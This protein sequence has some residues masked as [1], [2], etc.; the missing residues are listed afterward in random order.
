MLAWLVA[1]R[2]K[3]GTRSGGLG[4]IFSFGEAWCPF[5]NVISSVCVQTNYTVATQYNQ[6]NFSKLETL[7]FK[8]S[9][10]I[11]L[12]N[13]AH[14]IKFCMDESRNCLDKNTVIPQI[15]F[16]SFNIQCHSSGYEQQIPYVSYWVFGTAIALDESILLIIRPLLTTANAPKAN[17]TTV[18]PYVPNNFSLRKKNRI[19]I[20]WITIFNNLYF[21]LLEK[22]NDFQRFLFSFWMYR[23]TMNKTN[24]FDMEIIAIWL[25]N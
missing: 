12:L 24:A 8:F 4:Q 2:S 17:K 14:F 3:H 21:Y 9:S 1:T 13:P 6:Q 25:H 23:T 22:D 18:V 20:L 15:V 10:Q 19:F 7:M 5:N 11:L 16:P